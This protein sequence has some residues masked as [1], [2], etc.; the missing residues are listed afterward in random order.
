MDKDEFQAWKDSPATKWVLARVQS[1]SRLTQE[2][3]QELLFQSAQVEAQ[4]WRNLQAR[5]AYEL[6]MVT[7]LNYVVQL[8]HEEIADEPSKVEAR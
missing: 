6:G 5:A 7:G 2:G 3:V 4:T 1:K 8:E